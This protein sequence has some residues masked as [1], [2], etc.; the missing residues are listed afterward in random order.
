MIN[1]YVDDDLIGR[2]T[3][4]GFV[5]VTNSDEF[6]DLLNE[7]IDNI[8]TISFDNDLGLNSLEGYQLVNKVVEIGTKLK[9]INLHSANVVAVNSTFRMLKRC[10][11]LGIIKLDKLT[12]IPAVE[13]VKKYS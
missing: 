4:K 5:R 2:P 10:Q 9:Y 1:I 3:P 11:E 6:I 8:D 7:N 12:A 13:F